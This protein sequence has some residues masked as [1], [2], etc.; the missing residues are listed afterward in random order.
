MT[1]GKRVFCYTILTT[2]LAAIVLVVWPVSETVKVFCIAW[3]F[4]W[5]V[6]V[7]EWAFPLFVDWAKKKRRKL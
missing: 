1:T 3:V 6:L 2:W 5:F 4:I 7:P